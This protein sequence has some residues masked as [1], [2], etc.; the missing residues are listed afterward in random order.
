[1]NPFSAT[2]VARVSESA[3]DFFTVSTGAVQ[4][5]LSVLAESLAPATEAAPPA[6]LMALVGDHGTGKT[7]LCVE[8]SRHARRLLPNRVRTVYLDAPAA[9]FLALHRRFTEVLPRAEVV[10]AAHALPDT[11]AAVIPGRDVATCLDLLRDP[12]HETAAW[13]WL[14]GVPP[15]AA[16]TARGI[17]RPV[18][19]EELGIEVMAAIATL[20][21]RSGRRLVLI[22]DEIEKILS[23][24]SRSNAAAGSAFR[25]FLS[26]FSSTGAVLVLSGVPDW[27]QVLDVDV[28]QRVG[29]IVKMSSMAA[30]DTVDLIRK[31]HDRALGSPRLEPFSEQ[32]AE[33]IT[34]L[35]DGVPR[36]VVRVCYQLH[37]RASEL[38]TPVTYAMVRDVIRT[39]FDLISTQ[40]VRSEIRRILNTEGRTF[41]RDHLLGAVRDLPVDFW[42]P[43]G[44]ERSGCCLLL[45]E[46]VLKSDDV[47]NLIR[48]ADAV[49]AATDTVEVQLIVVGYLPTDFEWQLT[50]GFGTE[51][52]VYDPKGFAEDLSAAVRG[53]I[54]RLEELLGVD[55]LLSVGSQLERISRQ[56]THGQ[57][58]VEQLTT[59][60]DEIRRS[61]EHQLST[62]Q[63]RV[64][65]PEEHRPPAGHEEPAA[66][67]AEAPLPHRVESLFTGAL[68]ALDEIGRVDTMFDAFRVDDAGRPRRDATQLSVRSLVRSNELLPALGV[69]ILLREMV[70]AFRAGVAAWL[71]HRRS[72]AGS[73]SAATLDALCETY[74]SEFEEM[75]LFRLDGLGELAAWRSGRVD[76]VS[77]LLWAQQ[78]VEIRQTL[79]SLA[80]RVR[81]ESL[82]AIANSG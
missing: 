34:Q 17:T 40:E 72:A 48:R 23:A 68:A 26:A 38:G 65:G 28:R 46:A 50:A 2:A 67:E 7:H 62:L 11:A 45:T 4:E 79:E 19:T 13:E 80:A 53:M 30:D 24:S 27:L 41:L 43:V 20:L 15:G 6:V 82:R 29:H 60:L 57:R 35:C 76:A 44:A 73:D 63:R 21:H 78:R 22:V 10:A 64:S 56:Q 16:L 81:T 61:L 51:P 33:Y 25:T 36:R 3:T 69:T 42:L 8:L 39:Y 77:Q 18:S 70:G 54:A 58:S 14:C 66:A 32:T 37:R 5:A 1:M 71:S 49:R 47:D 52:I 31:S 75:P 74:E 59:H 55:P 9:T 12:E